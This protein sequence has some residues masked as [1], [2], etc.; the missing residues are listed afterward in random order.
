MIYLISDK[1][2]NHY[3]LC[4]NQKKCKNKTKGRWLINEEM[5]KLCGVK[6]KEGMG[7]VKSLIIMCE[8]FDFP[9]SS[10]CCMTKEEILYLARVSRKY[11]FEGCHYMI[12]EDITN[13]NPENFQ[14]IEFIL[15]EGFYTYLEVR[16]IISED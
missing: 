4:K 8:K 6:R 13:L 14:I 11:V 1:H 16:I 12:L 10:Y 15:H 9:Y 7:V 3:A 2:F 5:A